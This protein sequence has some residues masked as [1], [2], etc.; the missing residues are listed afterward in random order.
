LKLLDYLSSFRWL[1]LDVP[2]SYFVRFRLPVWYAHVYVQ[3]MLLC[4]FSLL[5][6]MA[7]NINVSH[8]DL[9]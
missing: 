7:A 6:S 3:T 4:F 2:L 9:L 5:T 8:T 1:L